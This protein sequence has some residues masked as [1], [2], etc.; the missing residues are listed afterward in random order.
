MSKKRGGEGRKGERVAKIPF[1]IK[2]SLTSFS[3]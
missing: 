3:I 1:E 2:N